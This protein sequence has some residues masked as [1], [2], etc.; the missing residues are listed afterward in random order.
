MIYKYGTYT[1]DAG[2]IRINASESI[3]RSSNGKSQHKRVTHRLSGRLRAANQSAL[4]TAISD[5]KAAYADSDNDSV[6]AGLYFPD[7]TTATQHYLDSSAAIAGIQ[8]VDGP[9]F[10][11][12]G[13]AQY[14]TFRDYNV[15]LAA[16][17]QVGGSQL[18]FFSES[19]VL[20]GGVRRV[21]FLE[22]FDGSTPVK[23]QTGLRPYQCVQSGT[24][25]TQHSGYTPPTAL[26]ASDLIDQEGPSITNIKT[27]QGVPIEYHWK[28]TYRFART[29]SAFSGSPSYG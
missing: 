28:W 14:S 12:S 11:D 9:N 2:E 21:V 15:T 24:A 23:Q 5:L 1:H 17:F 16:D 3:V 7:G 25:I 26:F 10:P 27:H 20:S 6:N 22:P 29:G 13:N 19:L 18:L 8:V 4:D